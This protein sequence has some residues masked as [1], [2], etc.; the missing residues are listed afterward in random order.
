MNRDG[1]TGM[2][3]N[4]VFGITMGTEGYAVSGRVVNVGAG[5]N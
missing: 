5:G 3:G 1:M 4:A 2:L